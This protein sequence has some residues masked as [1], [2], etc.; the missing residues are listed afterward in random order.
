MEKG[1]F[2]AIFGALLH[3]LETSPDSKKLLFSRKL[4]PHVCFRR[5]DRNRVFMIECKFSLVTEK[6]PGALPHGTTESTYVATAPCESLPPACAV[7]ALVTFLSL[8]SSDAVGQRCL[9][10]GS[11]AACWIGYDAFGDITSVQTGICL[12]TD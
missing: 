3:V 8:V 12:A 4:T 9:L 5:D 11:A 1:S 6:G 2:A 7:E 10:T